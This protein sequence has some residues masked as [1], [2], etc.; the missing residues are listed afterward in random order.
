MTRAAIAVICLFMLAQASPAQKKTVLKTKKDTLSYTIGVN[1]GA[2]FRQQSINVEPNLVLAGIRD[3]MAARQGPLTEEQLR[4]VMMAFQQEMMEKQDEMEKKM[5]AENKLKSE[6]FLDANKK[7]D[8]VV[9][10]PSGLQYKVLRPGTGKSPTDKD[11]VVAHYVGTLINGKE[12][13]NSYKRGEP[14]TFPVTGVIKGWTEAL[15]LM[16][17]GAKWRLFIPSDLAYGER[18]AGGVIG[19]NEALIFD[20]ELLSIK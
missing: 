5:A 3:G 19:P 13:D 6:A 10:L 14:A 20:V 11:T 4:A 15:K 17:V 2:G 1:I 18:G 12:F 7:L 16:Q 8:S 9:T